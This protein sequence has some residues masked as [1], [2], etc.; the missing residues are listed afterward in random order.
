MDVETCRSTQASMKNQ[1]SQLVSTLGTIKS[2]VDSTI[3]SAWV[4]NSAT[5]FQQQFEQLRSSMN[6]QLDQLSQLADAMNNEI[7]QWEA[8][9]SHLG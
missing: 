3:G 7:A 5:E 8:M 1:Q 9:A 4:G 6:T 2:A